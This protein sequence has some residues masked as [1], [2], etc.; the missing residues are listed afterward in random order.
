MTS[1]EKIEELWEKMVK[2]DAEY[3]LAERGLDLAVAEHGLSSPEAVEVAQR[4]DQ[5]GMRLA[6]LD[7]E[8]TARLKWAGWIW[9][10]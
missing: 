8:Y 1:E 10:E 5:L 6:R 9:D 2:L 7:A 4:L 3:E